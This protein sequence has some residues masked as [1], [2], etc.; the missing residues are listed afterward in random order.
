MKS[1]F[2]DDEL[3]IKEGLSLEDYDLFLKQHFYHNKSTK[4]NIRQTCFDLLLDPECE[5][6][7]IKEKKVFAIIVANTIS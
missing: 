3:L 1:G 2:F 4:L 7:Q 6:H 5:P